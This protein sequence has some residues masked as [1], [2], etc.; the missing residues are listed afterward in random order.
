MSQGKYGKL[1]VR[2]VLVVQLVLVPGAVYLIDHD[3]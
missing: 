2:Q 1:S 3:P